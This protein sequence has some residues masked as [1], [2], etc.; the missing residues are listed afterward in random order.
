M[1]NLPSTAAIY[2]LPSVHIPPAPA[3]ATL[4]TGMMTLNT[5]QAQDVIVA[6]VMT[7]S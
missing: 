4:T 2:P 3:I 5:L 7:N 6:T 1:R